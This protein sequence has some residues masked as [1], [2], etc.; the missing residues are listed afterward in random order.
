M[1]YKGCR[2]RY[3][4]PKGHIWDILPPH[5]STS[6]HIHLHTQD[7]DTVINGLRDIYGTFLLDTH[8]PPHT[9]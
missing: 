5:T 9:G 3:Q 8:P 4:W 6:T 7:A 1:T 2:H